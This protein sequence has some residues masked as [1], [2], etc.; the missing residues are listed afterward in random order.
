MTEPVWRI[1]RTIAVQESRVL[2]AYVRAGVMWP[3][4]APTAFPWSP[5]WV[6]QTRDLTKNELL[7]DATDRSDQ[8]H[9]LR[10]AV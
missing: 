1:C 6:N 7:P 4:A 10:K 8:P 9:M 3:K 5:H 2:R